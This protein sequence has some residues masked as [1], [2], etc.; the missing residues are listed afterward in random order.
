M[1]T[2][3]ELLTASRF[4]LELRLDGS[5]DLVD[6][7]FL[8]CQGFKRS[9]EP[10]KIC[11]VTPQQWGRAKYGRVVETQL[12]GSSKTDNLVLRRGLTNSM[13]LWTW[14]EAVEVG[15]WAKQRRDGALCIYSQAGVEQ[16]RFEFRNAWPT[17]YSLSDFSA[18]SG[19][20]EIE[21]LEIVVEDFSRKR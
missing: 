14:F 7:V 12:P 18:Q 5:N 13:T 21:E 1:A 19:E 4:Y 16:A 3:A 8:E 20:M 10:I 9:Q 11:E 2:F 6:A 15:D 17:R